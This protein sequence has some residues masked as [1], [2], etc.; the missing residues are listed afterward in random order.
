MQLFSIHMFLKSGNTTKMTH[1]ALKPC[2]HLRGDNLDKVKENL[3]IESNKF[4]LC[5]LYQKRGSLLCM[6]FVC[7]KGLKK[8]NLL[9]G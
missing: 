6:H 7:K 4:Y 8:L 9:C 5:K 2:V 1:P 3:N